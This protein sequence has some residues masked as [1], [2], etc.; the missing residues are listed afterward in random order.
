MELSPSSDRGTKDV[1]NFLLVSDIHL[2]YDYLDKLLIWEESGG[3]KGVKKYDYVL[4][5]GD[6]GNV[7]HSVS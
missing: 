4:G 3:N 7:N 5:S 2:A 1:L 6:F